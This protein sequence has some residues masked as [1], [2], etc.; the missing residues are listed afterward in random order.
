LAVDRFRAM[1]IARECA[2]APIIGEVESEGVELGE[3]HAYPLA[4]ADRPREF[5]QMTS[6]VAYLTK[7]FPS[8]PKVL[9]SQRGP[10]DVFQ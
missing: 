1:M 3:L 6:R 9:L 7:T 4:A 8:F 10:Y 5:A 2:E